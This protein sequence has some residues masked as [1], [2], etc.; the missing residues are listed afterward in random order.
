MAGEDTGERE[1][2]RERER[3][4]ARRAR[5]RNVGTKKNTVDSISFLPVGNSTG[6]NV[7]GGKRRSP[8]LPGLNTTTTPSEASECE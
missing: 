6:S 4:E 5:K 2:E 8:S 3:E 1:R 7:I